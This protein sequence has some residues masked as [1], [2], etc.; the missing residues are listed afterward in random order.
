MLA[1]G[2]YL[3]DREANRRG[4]APASPWMRTGGVRLAC[5]PG[6]PARPTP[7]WPSSPSRSRG[8]SG[9]LAEE[10]SGSTTPLGASCSR[11]VAQEPVVLVPHD[12]VALARAGLH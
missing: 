12:R 6:T 10:R 3:H 1:R 8:C 4:T 5:H 2:D 11:R 7:S 9:L